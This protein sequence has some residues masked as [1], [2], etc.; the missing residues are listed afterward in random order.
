GREK[1]GRKRRTIR[2]A[3]PL[4]KKGEEGRGRLSTFHRKEN[5]VDALREERTGLPRRFAPRND[6][7]GGGF[8]MTRRC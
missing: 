5:S 3:A 8:A 4:D 1:A 7:V 6:E 2:R